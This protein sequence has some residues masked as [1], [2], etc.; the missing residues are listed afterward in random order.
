MCQLVAIG[1]S[2]DLKKKMY[3][4]KNRKRNYMVRRERDESWF[5]ITQHLSG[6]DINYFSR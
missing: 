5:E 6:A 4:H 2:H 3:Q 1:M